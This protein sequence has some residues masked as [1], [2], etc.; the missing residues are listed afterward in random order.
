MRTRIMEHLA[1]LGPKE[2]GEL[3]YELGEEVFDIRTALRI[4]YQRGEVICVNDEW[5]VRE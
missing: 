3:A 5:K 2:T 1:A 4:L